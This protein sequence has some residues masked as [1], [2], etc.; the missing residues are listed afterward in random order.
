M[1]YHLIGKNYTQLNGGDF[2]VRVPDSWVRWWQSQLP[3]AMSRKGATGLGIQVRLQVPEPE[4][5]EPPTFHALTLSL[6]P[7]PQTWDASGWLWL[8]DTLT[9]SE[10]SRAPY[11]VTITRIVSPSLAAPRKAAMVRACSLV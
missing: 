9:F 1:D 5:A 3:S 6:R 2:R 4:Q 7:G 10:T 11:P 8:S